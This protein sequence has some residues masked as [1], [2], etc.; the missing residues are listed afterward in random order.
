[1]ERTFE[2][3][4]AAQCAPT[5]A[6]V[7]PASLFRWQTRDGHA[8]RGTMRAW[9]QTMKPMGLRM[10]VLKICRLDDAFLIYVYR[11]RQLNALLA[12]GKTQDFLKETGYLPG[13][14]GSMLE[15]LSLRLGAGGEFPHEIGVFLGYPLEDV[16]GFIRH[17]GRNFTCAGCWKAYGDPV[18]AQAAFSRYHKCT[19]IY[20]KLL[21][22]GVPLRNLI[23]A[24]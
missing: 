2:Q 22:R 12:D 5:L 14:C 20:L 3:V 13:D 4:L 15:Q 19:T 21:A 7:K 23:V 6:G 11:E 24:A 16:K 17:A 10:Q 18:Q 9:K 8:A 1:M